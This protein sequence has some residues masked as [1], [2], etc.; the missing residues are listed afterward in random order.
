MVPKIC[1]Q[2]RQPRRRRGEVRIG[3]PFRLADQI[4][5][6]APDRRL[7]DEIDVGVG[8]GLPA[9][10]FQDP[11]G[12]AAAGIVA[13]ARH[14]LPEGNAFAEL[15]VF[16]QRAVRQPL[17]VAQFHARKIEHAVLHG[18][19]HLLAAAGPHP[20][21]E[22]G[23]DAEGEMQAGAA[24]AD[25][26]AGDER[27]AVAEAGGGSRAAGALRDVLINLAVL[28]RAGAEA[29]HRGDD[30]ARV[31]LMDVFPGEA[32]AVERAGCEI[33][34]QHVAM[35]DQPV[36]DLLALRVLGVDGDRALVAVEHREI[37]AVRAFDV[38][39]LPARDVADARPLDLDHVGAHIAE[40]LGAGR[41]RLHMREVEHA[42]A[43][44]RL[45][46]LAIGPA[47]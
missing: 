28:V 41:A 31:E 26:R 42:H 11:A 33:L 8:I 37:E 47:A 4:A 43:V 12:L 7:G 6:H 15:A 30:H 2:P 17:L 13:G 10:A 34:H 14:R 39:Q 46:G 25:L 27:R 16:G 9:F 35:L 45:A 3:L 38:A 24:V 36:D 23:D 1:L 29:L 18:A 20:L 21:I 44:E 5:D 22:R 19:E 32:H 40:Q